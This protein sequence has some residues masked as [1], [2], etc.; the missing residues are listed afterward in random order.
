MVEAGRS[1]GMT[2][3]FAWHVTGGV[4]K[5]G[6]GMRRREQRKNV[7][8]KSDRVTSRGI[9]QAVRRAPAPRC[10]AARIPATAR[11]VGSPLFFPVG[12]G[13]SSISESGLESQIL[14]RD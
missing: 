12:K 11:S 7:S 10:D 5:K 13:E 14:S 1:G 3:H 2:P 8:A 4:V 6:K 9:D